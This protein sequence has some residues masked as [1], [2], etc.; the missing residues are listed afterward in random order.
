M[1][2]GQ[3]EELSGYFIAGYYWSTNMAPPVRPASGELM[4]LSSGQELRDRERHAILT[5][6][7]G[8]LESP[9]VIVQRLVH[10]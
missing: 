5:I 8:L 1:G 4:I 6:F 7:F 2:G 10:L 9:I 3:E